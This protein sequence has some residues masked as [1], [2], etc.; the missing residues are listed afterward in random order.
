MLQEFNIKGYRRFCDITF[1]NLSLINVI[2]G[3]NNCGKTTFLE[4][5]YAWCCGVKLSPMLLKSIL[6]QR[7]PSALKLNWI[8]ILEAKVNNEEMIKREGITD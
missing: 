2:A 1:R 4:A 8:L 6:R 5:I 3:K 7:E